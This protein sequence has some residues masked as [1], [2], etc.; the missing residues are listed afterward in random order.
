MFTI[1]VPYL[2][3]YSFTGIDVHTPSDAKRSANRLSSTFS[4]SRRRFGRHFSQH[5]SR[6]IHQFIPSLCLLLSIPQFHRH[7]LPSGAAV[8]S[9]HKTNSTPRRR[10]AMSPVSEPPK[11]APRQ[12]QPQLHP[13]LHR[14]MVVLLQQLL[15]LRRRRLQRHPLPA[16]PR[17]SPPS[18]A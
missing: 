18:F 6:N 17:S 1:T 11:A 5:R 13:L 12:L 3:I 4:G 10:R 14:R 7:P 9:G 2:F 16:A 15:L 8:G